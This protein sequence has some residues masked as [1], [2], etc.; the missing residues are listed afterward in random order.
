MRSPQVAAC[1][2]LAAAI[3][4]AGPP[5][6]A[7]GADDHS[8][9]EAMDRQL[10]GDAAH[11]AVATEALERARAALERA[12]R[13]RSAGDETHAKAADGLAREW[14]EDARDIARAADAEAASAE[15]RRKAVDAQAQLERTRAL[16][17]EGIA[18][19]GRLKAELEQAERA[20]ATPAPSKGRRAVEVHAG[21]PAATA[22]APPAGKAA[23]ATGGKAAA[24]TGGKAATG[25]TP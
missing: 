7:Q 22:A 4:T 8:T 3:A 15:V 14:A 16:V 6:K 18:R 1:S 20:A 21:E 13:L 2:L 12:T 5:A 19:I 9:A 10:E 24:A 17:E 11:R 23:A 25:G